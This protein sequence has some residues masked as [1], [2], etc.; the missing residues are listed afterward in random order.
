[1]IKR[2]QGE[3]YAHQ[4]VKTVLRSRDDLKV[5]G[6]LIELV[7]RELSR[8]EEIASSARDQWGNWEWPYA[9][10]VRKGNLYRPHL[11][12]AILEWAV[13]NGHALPE[14]ASHRW[15]GGKRFALCLTHDVDFISRR[16]TSGAFVRELLS[17][18]AR[19]PYRQKRFVASQCLRQVAKLLAGPLLSRLRSDEY[20]CFD[21][22]MDLEAKHGFTS[23]FFMFAE[24]L[25]NPHM[26]DCGYSHGDQLQFYGARV[27][28]REM[29]RDMR[30]RGWDIGLHGSY[31]AA[32]NLAALCEEKRQVEESVEAPVETIR[33]HYLHYDARVTPA[34]H[35]QA[36]FK[37]DSTQG[38]NRN[39]GF[40]AGTSFPYFSWNH[41]AQR[42]TQVWEIPMHIMDGPLFQLNSLECDLGTAIAYMKTLMDRIEAVGGC[43]TV[44]WHPCWLSLPAFAGMYRAI[45]EEA[46]RR[47][48]WGC[49][50]S[51]LVAWW[52][53][54]RGKVPSDNSSRDLST[55]LNPNRSYV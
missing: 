55:V 37:A 43:L 26:W 12:E 1:M 32:T 44:N 48:A 15:P 23:T 10:A 36:G 11:D 47:A 17:R 14:A 2:S 46:A 3:D 39:V 25:P 18:V 41:Q 7:Y 31:H 30:Q 53:I 27:T 49:N 35:E 34:L 8:Q 13:Q 50:A 16:S 54:D 38:F 21:L 24:H 45:L 5:P 52:Q 19:V 40:R 33:H 20:H 9:A 28:V 4:F 22:C 51:G 42:A 6:E 29:I